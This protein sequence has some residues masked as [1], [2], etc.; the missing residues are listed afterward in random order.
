MVEVEFSAIWTQLE[1]DR[2]AGQADPA[3]EGKSDDALK[4][5][6]RAIAERRVRLGLL[7]SEVGQR[8]N[9][10]ISQDD[11]N[12]AVLAEARKHPGQEQAVF[13]YY[14]RNNDALNSLRAPVFEEKVVDFILEL[15]QVS[16]KVVTLD[17]LRR[18]PD[19]RED[20]L[21]AAPADEEAKPE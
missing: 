7:L 5:E 14:Q 6:Y 1:K 2:V 18:D 9:I 4:Q 15:A 17:E 16:D 11:L 20:A 3:D 21:S 19:V 8:N 10:T 13:Q 12:H